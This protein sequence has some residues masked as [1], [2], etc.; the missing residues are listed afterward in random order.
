MQTDERQRQLDEDYLWATHDP[1]VQHCHGGQVVVVYQRR[2]VGAGPNLQEAWQDARSRTA[3]P[4]QD[5]VAFVPV[6]LLTA[7]QDPDFAWCLQNTEVRQRYGGLVAAVHQGKVWGAG[8]NRDEA[9]RDSQRL[10]GCPGP[11]ELTF[12]LIP[13]IEDDQLPGG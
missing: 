1:A 11:G 10:A 9:W 2:V 3:C 5:D 4:P 7:D 6:P 8:A 13:G 12:V